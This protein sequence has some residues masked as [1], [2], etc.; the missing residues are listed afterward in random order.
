MVWSVRRNIALLN[1]DSNRS[2]FDMKMYIPPKLKSY[3]GK[4][5]YIHTRKNMVWSVHRKSM[6]IWFVASRQYK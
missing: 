4:H 2:E 5:T 3:P 6:D 1:I